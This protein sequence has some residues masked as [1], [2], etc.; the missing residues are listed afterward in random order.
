VFVKK[1]DHLVDA[2][3]YGFAG[4]FPEAEPEESEAK[5]VWEADN[6]RLRRPTM[7]EL[8]AL[9]LGAAR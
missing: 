2:L 7:A 5:R 9:E 1:N 4:I 6:K 8:D 3:G